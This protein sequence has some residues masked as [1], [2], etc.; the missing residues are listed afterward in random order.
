VTGNETCRREFEKLERDTI[1]RNVLSKFLWRRE[2]NFNVTRI[3]LERISKNHTMFRNAYIT[4]DDSGTYGLNVVEAT[5]L[6]NLVKTYGNMSDIV[7]IYPGADEVGLT[8]LSKS[9]SF[10]SNPK[11]R[12]VWRVPNAT[13]FIPN[14]ESQAV[15]LT[16]QDQLEAAGFKVL[17]NDSSLSSIQQ[18]IPDLIFAVNNFEISPQLESTKQPDFSPLSDYDDLFRECFSDLSKNVPVAFADV[19]YSNGADKSFVKY[20]LSKLKTNM[21]TRIAYAGWNTD[22]NTL[23]TAACNGMLLSQLDDTASKQE[24]AA[25]CFTYLRLVEDCSYQ[26]DVR[27]VLISKVL[28]DGG[29]V[30]DLTPHL[31]DYESFVFQ[32]L[33]NESQSFSTVLNLPF[34]TLKSV[35]FPWNRTFEI[36]LNV[37]C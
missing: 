14:F 16:V 15:F 4:L 10:R 35:Y 25:R 24:S 36:G 17:P 21:T 29:D 8:L 34:P 27:N 31:K 3:L 28:E 5:A 23:G 9:L 12:V 30:T 6:K 1:P 7:R 2:R 22:G 13:H 32:H 33:T 26:S 18:Q 11:V 20:L 19:R 37:N